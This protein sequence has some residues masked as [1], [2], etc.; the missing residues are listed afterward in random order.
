MSSFSPE[1]A[2]FL[3]DDHDDDCVNTDK[4][5]LQISSSQLITAM[6]QQPMFT[7]ASTDDDDDDDDARSVEEL[8]LR[9]LQ[10]E[11]EES[12]ALVR[13][14]MAEEAMASYQH[15]FDLLRE[16]ADHLLQEDY[17][18]LQSALEEEE[19]E[20]IASLENENGELS[21]DTM[22]ELGER[23]GDVKSERWAIVAAKEV[24][25][26]PTF[27]FEAAAFNDTQQNGEQFVDGERKC[28]VCQCDYESNEELRRLPCGHC[29]HSG[30]VDQWLK[31]RDSCPYCRQ[32]IVVSK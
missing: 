31:D 21:Y 22:L 24:E 19:Q 10:E 18:A 11:E 12:I 2:K 4:L 23:I 13:Q 29:F 15:H 3:C 16:S 5:S 32:C 26:L 28:L 8:R 14:L 20:H 7:P 9:R 17:D 30:C 6:E 1:R 25:K 27:R